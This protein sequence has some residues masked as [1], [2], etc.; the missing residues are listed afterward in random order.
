MN[1]DKRSGDIILLMKDDPSDASENRFSTAYACKSWHGSLNK[2]DSYVPLVVSYPGGNK[3]EFSSMLTSVCPNNAC[4]GN[5]KMTDLI[6]KIIET[7][8]LGQ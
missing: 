4:E 5:W 2:S 7:Q 6:K 1:H 3:K 8:Y